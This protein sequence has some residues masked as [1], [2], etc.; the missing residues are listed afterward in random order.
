MRRRMAGGALT[1]VAALAVMALIK[2]TVPAA[3][4]AASAWQQE[5]FDHGAGT[6]IVGYAEGSPV[7]INV[8]TVGGARPDVWGVEIVGDTI[9]DVDLVANGIQGTGA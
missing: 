1:S 8:I 4:S 5:V 6:H 9:R 7:H 2:V 3:D